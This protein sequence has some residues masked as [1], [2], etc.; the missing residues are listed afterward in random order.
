MISFFHKWRFTVSATKPRVVAF[1]AGE[2]RGSLKDC[3]WSIGGRSID[4]AVM[5]TYLEIDL[6]KQGWASIIKTNCTEA[7]IGEN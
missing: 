2:T 3:P 6:E 1:G 7:R 4:E 5:Y